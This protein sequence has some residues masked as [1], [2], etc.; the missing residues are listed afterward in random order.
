VRLTNGAFCVDGLLAFSAAVCWVLGFE[1]RKERLGGRARVKISRQNLVKSFAAQSRKRARRPSPPNQKARPRSARF[2]S[3]ICRA[4]VAL[5]MLLQRRSTSTLH[6]SSIMRTFVVTL[7]LLL[8][9]GS[10]LVRHRRHNRRTD[11]ATTV[12]LHHVIVDSSHSTNE[13]CFRIQFSTRT[14]VQH[15]PSS[16]HTLYPPILPL[17]LSLQN[18]V[19][20][21]EFDQLFA[22]DQCLVPGT[23]DTTAAVLGPCNTNQFPL[24]DAASTL[25]CYNRQPSRHLFHADNRQPL[26][27]IDYR[28]VRCYPNDWH[29]CSSCTPGRYCKSESRCILEEEGYPCAEWI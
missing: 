7:T 27:Y 9:H 13:C 3:A 5:D 2:A 21:R 6:P 17:L 11:A 16:S 23:G 1:R 28:N 10:F 22:T 26:Y 12:A 19:Q 20:A 8:S 29:G 18:M 14:R 4:C 24:C 25:I 15:S